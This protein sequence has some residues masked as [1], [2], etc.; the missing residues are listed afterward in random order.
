MLQKSPEAVHTPQ[1]K[2]TS[3]PTPVT[4]G[5]RQPDPPRLAPNHRLP[6]KTEMASPE[7]CYLM[8][9]F[10][11]MW[12]IKP[13]YVVQGEISKPI[14]HRTLTFELRQL[15]SNSLGGAGR[16]RL[17]T[18]QPRFCCCMFGGFGWMKGCAEWLQILVFEIHECLHFKYVYIYIHM[19]YLFSCDGNKSKYI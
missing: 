13:V 3:T 19:W 11:T 4:P 10:L 8:A 9:L 16:E 14:N 12:N 5:S 17:G 6:S 2:E 1:C 7:D 15:L 18:C